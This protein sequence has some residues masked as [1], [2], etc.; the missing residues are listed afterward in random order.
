MDNILPSQLQE[1]TYAAYLDRTLDTDIKLALNEEFEKVDKLERIVLD[2]D[3]FIEFLADYIN[4]EAT[5]YA[6][7]DQGE[8]REHPHDGTRT[9]PLCTCS[10]RY[11]ALKEATLPRPIR[12]AEEPQD[13]IRR[14]KHEHRGDPLVLSDALDVYDD[15]RAE[16]K[17]IFRRIYVCATE[18]IHPDELGEQEGNRETD[19]SEETGQRAEA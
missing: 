17:A 3:G 19:E 9:K 12:E 15:K 1:E 5:K 14:F 2:E 16:Y 10:D 18:Q 6:A 11:C 4:R 8:P 13:A 7:Y